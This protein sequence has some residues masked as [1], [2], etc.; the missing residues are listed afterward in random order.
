MRRFTILYVWMHLFTGTRVIHKEKGKGEKRAYVSGRVR[1]VYLVARRRLFSL[2]GPEVVGSVK[3]ESKSSSTLLDPC[4]D[5]IFV[6]STIWRNK[7]KN[8]LKEECLRK[9]VP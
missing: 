3:R 5:R 9:T 1:G 4:I 7:S 2:G 6:H 8:K